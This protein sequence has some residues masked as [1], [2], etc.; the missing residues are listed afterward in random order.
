MQPLRAPKLGRYRW[1]S[2]TGC[3]LPGA[4][5]QESISPSSCDLTGLDMS[6]A[7]CNQ[8][9]VDVNQGHQAAFLTRGTVWL[10]RCG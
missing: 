6:A 1:S 8:R 5:R 10:I 3:E 9:R 2:P 4:A 7:G